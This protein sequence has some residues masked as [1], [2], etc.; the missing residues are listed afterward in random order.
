MQNMQNAIVHT[1]N[2]TAPAFTESPDLAAAKVGGLVLVANDEF[3]APKENLL[4]SEVPVFLPDEY[5]DRGKWMDGWETRRSR[6]PG[7]DWCILQLGIPGRIEGFDLDVAGELKRRAGAWLEEKKA[8]F[9]KRAKELG[10]K[11]DLIEVK[12]LTQDMLLAL[13]EKGIKTLDD[14]GDLAGDELREI[15]GADQLTETQA[16]A[17]IM[18]ARAGW[19]ADADKASA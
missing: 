17:V 6:Q 5:T 16:N 13:G 11:K 9:D 15:V 8:V 14:L 12:G 3:F 7:Y 18:T 2:Q 10:L 19:F 4:R 1:S